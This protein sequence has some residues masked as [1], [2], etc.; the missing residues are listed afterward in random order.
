ML[1]IYFIGTL[2]F[3]LSPE[4]L[5]IGEI[6]LLSAELLSFPV[7][8][9]NIAFIAQFFN[10]LAALL[11][12]NLIAH[13]FNYRTLRQNVI[14]GMSKME[15]ILSKSIMIF[16]V[17]GLLTLF[18]ILIGLIIGTI[19]TGGFNTEVFSKTDFVI[20]FFIQSLG[21]LSFAM[22]LTF[23][24]R[25]TG[26]T[27]LVFL[28]YIIAFEPIL[29]SNLEGEAVKY[30]PSKSIFGIIKMPHHQLLETAGGWMQETALVP[31]LLSTS[32]YAGLFI[33]LSFLLI[34]NRDL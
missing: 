23:L 30:F 3:F 5:S 8:W 16:L 24:F 11:V 17:S 12:I 22:L 2:L 13:E 1:G 4:V 10:I 21:L 14:D 15:F 6:K 31:Q 33:F 19:N 26:I 25:R 9:Q 32:L 29:R 27:T 18:L 7:V 34:R 28:L 20:G